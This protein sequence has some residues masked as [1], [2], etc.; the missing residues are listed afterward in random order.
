M[1]YRTDERSWYDTGDLTR[2]LR[3]PAGVWP[4]TCSGLCFNAENGVINL[5]PLRGGGHHHSRSSIIGVFITACSPTQSA[6]SDLVRCTMQQRVQPWPS[7][8]AQ[9]R[10][11][12][13]FFNKGDFQP[14]HH[15]KLC[16]LRTYLSVKFADDIC[17]CS[18]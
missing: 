8:V 6:L 16:S 14:Q 1:T 7:C 18:R 10:Y 2:Q 3:A 11:A 15:L 4:N 9:S 12:G 5:A 17:C 13:D